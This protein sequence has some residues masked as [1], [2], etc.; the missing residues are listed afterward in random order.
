MLQR[1]VFHIRVLP[2]HL[3]DIHADGAYVRFSGLSWREKLLHSYPDNENCD[4]SD[5]M[6]YAHDETSSESILRIDLKWCI[7]MLFGAVQRKCH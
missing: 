7:A 6:M 3:K 5:D 4:D 1:K 2:V